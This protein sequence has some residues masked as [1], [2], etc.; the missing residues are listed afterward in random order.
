MAAGVEGDFA[1]QA[2]ES[3][4]QFLERGAAQVEHAV[5]VAAEPLELALEVGAALRI[6]HHVD[7]GIAVLEAG[8]LDSRR[9]ARQALAG[10]VAKHEARRMLV[11]AFAPPD[12]G[13]LP[14]FERE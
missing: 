2:M 5:A 10:E 8:N 7:A 12:L 9:P 6:D 1:A 4:E 11:A 3:P 13:L 14:A